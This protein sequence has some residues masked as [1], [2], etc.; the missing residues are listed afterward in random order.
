MTLT[1]W[2]VE[3]KKKQKIKNLSLAIYPVIA[4]WKAVFLKPKQLDT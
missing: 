2:Y 3:K 4:I 1:F